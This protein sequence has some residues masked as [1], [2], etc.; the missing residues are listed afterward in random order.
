MVFHRSRI[1]GKGC[2]I[3][4]GTVLFLRDVVGATW[5][6]I[7]PTQAVVMASHK[8]TFYLFQNS[9]VP[10]SEAGNRNKFR[11]RPQP[12][13]LPRAWPV[14]SATKFGALVKRSIRTLQQPLRSSSAV[15]H[16]VQLFCQRIV[17][18]Y[19]KRR[20]AFSRSALEHS[21]SKRT[22]FLQIGG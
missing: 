14:K 9:L 11:R 12:T 7:W 1:K 18:S 22:R 20:G 19:L 3:P 5:I 8:S 21:F 10:T 16:F 6:R 4:F 15:L 13:A 17:G 2:S